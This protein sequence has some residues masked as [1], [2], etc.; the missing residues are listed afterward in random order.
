MGKMKLKVDYRELKKDPKFAGMTKKKIKKS[1]RNDRVI[2]PDRAHKLNV[3]KKKQ[4]GKESSKQFNRALKKELIVHGL[5]DGQATGREGPAEHGETSFGPHTSRYVP[6]RE[7]VLRS[8]ASAPTVAID[9]D[10]PIFKD[11]NVSSPVLGQF[12]QSVGANAGD[13]RKVQEP[14]QSGRDGNQ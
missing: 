11:Q 8:L 2:T 4:S 1:L 14:S 6:Q 7:G 3:K 10:F 13:R 9:L 5:T 12:D